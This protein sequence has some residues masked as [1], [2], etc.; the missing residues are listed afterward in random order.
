MNN[1]KHLPCFLFTLN[2]IAKM[3][4]SRYV[5]FNKMNASPTLYQTGTHTNPSSFRPLSRV[6]N[7][8]HC[9][10]GW[11]REPLTGVFTFSLSRPLYLTVDINGDH[12]ERT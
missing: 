11:Q 4:T 10:V 5:H 3:F 1:G 7:I 6:F 12:P 2:F 8:L 9:M